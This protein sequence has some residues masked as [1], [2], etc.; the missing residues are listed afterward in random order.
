MY[1]AADLHVTPADLVAFA[2]SAPLRDSAARAGLSDV[3]LKRL[4]HGHGIVTPPQGHWNRVHAGRPVPRPPTPKPR[5][6]G[7][8]G[9]IRLDTRFRGLVADTGPWP[10]DGPFATALVPESLDELRAAVLG[11]TRPARVPRL[12]TR[13]H[14]GVAPL[15]RREEERAAKRSAS[16]QFAEAPHF[17]GP[18]WQRQLR[19]L[20]ALFLTLA[21]HGARG[22]LHETDG[23]LAASVEVGSTSVPLAF[24]PVGRY[25]REQLAGVERPASDL[26]ATTPL[27][28]VT[29]TGEDAVRRQDGVGEP[30]EAQLREVV[31]DV[32][33]AGEAGFRRGLREHRAWLARMAALEEEAR[34]R[35]LAA[36]EAARGVRLGEQAAL[37]RAADEIRQLVARAR[38]TPPGTLDPAALEAWCAWALGR[39]DR[40][41]PL[42]SGALVAG[43]GLAPPAG[44]EPGS[45]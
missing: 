11:R 2:W 27:E 23:R 33:T 36:E 4:L 17:A 12:T 21:E 45:T 22:S 40:L 13:I 41:D 1:R 42:V 8:S 16:G 24:L 31:A 3:G 25:R 44:V 9:R 35:R 29:G 19:L 43:F 15:L 5:G 38:A 37:L 10:A 30:L 26:S 34:Q 7:E 6:P 32:I 20:N 14:P 28:L 39:A 18:F